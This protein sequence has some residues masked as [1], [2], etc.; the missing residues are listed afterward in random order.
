[1]SFLFSGQGKNIF[2]KYLNEGFIL[3][4]LFCFLA[5][6]LVHKDGFDLAGMH[7]QNFSK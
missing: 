4:V 2:G 6:P 7:C 3:F 5:C 1:M